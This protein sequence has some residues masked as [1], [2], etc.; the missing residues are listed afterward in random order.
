[1]KLNA[2]TLDENK[3]GDWELLRD[4][5]GK[6]LYHP[7][8]PLIK[9]RHQQSSSYKFYPSSKTKREENPIVGVAV[10]TDNNNNKSTKD[11]E[12]V[13]CDNNNNKTFWASPRLACKLNNNKVRPKNL[14]L[15]LPTFMMCELLCL[16]LLTD[17]VQVLSELQ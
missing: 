15:L 13:E 11:D 10:S 17:G 9:H 14:P 7:S 2:A 16:A 6:V 8:G 5:D 1:M 3:G 4:A 12:D